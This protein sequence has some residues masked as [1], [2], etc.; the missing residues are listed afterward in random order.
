MNIAT[1]CKM[2]FYQPHNYDNDCFCFK[3]DQV[4]SLGYN[5]LSAKTRFV[6]P[7]PFPFIYTWTPL[8]KFQMKKV[9]KYIKLNDWLSICV[10]VRGMADKPDDFN[11]KENEKKF[12]KIIFIKS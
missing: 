11:K 6:Q 4:D 3:K 12:E 2:S 5:W 10:D 1:N 7:T 9:W 8:W